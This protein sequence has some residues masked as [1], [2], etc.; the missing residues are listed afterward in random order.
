MIQG[1]N[2]VHDEFIQIPAG[3]DINGP[4]ALSELT[5]RRC[6][7]GNNRRLKKAGMDSCHQLQ[8]LCMCRDM[9]GHCQAVK[10]RRFYLP[11]ITPPT[12]RDQ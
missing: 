9:G 10:T 11:G 5:Q 2:P 4:P 12:L 7:L 8:L 1:I 6:P 3:G